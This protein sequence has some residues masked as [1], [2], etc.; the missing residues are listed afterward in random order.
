MR[1]TLYLNECH[2]FIGIIAVYVSRPEVFNIHVTDLRST[3][4]VWIPVAR[5][6]P[7]TWFILS[8]AFFSASQIF[9]LLIYCVFLSNTVCCVV[10]DIL[11]KESRQK[12]P[13]LG[14]NTGRFIMFSVIANIYNKKTKGPT[15][16]ELFTA[17][18]KLKKCFFLQL[19]LFD[20]CTTGDTAHI[21]TIF[22]STCW[23]VGGKNLNILSICAVSPVV[24]TSKISSCQKKTFSV[25]LCLWKIP[26]R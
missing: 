26:L 13:P 2:K 15:L 21:D 12:A 20:V 16:M 11:G 4:T 10:S 18:G 1:N 23:R 3:N 7:V 5:W 17:T 14:E 24:H 9:V 25:F 19:D 22:K 8:Y 6:Q